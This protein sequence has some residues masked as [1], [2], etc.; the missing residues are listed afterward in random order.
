ML[1]R[2]TL[3]PRTLPLSPVQVAPVH[4]LR[5]DRFIRHAPSQF[6]NGPTIIRQHAARQHGAAATFDFDPHITTQS[7][8]RDDNLTP[9]GD[10]R[11]LSWMR[12]GMTTVTCPGGI[13]A[14]CGRTR[15]VFHIG[16][17]IR[18]S[19]FVT[20]NSPQFDACPDAR[21]PDEPRDFRW[22][23]SEFVRGH[24]FVSHVAG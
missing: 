12:S 1:E 18:S 21:F 6:K 22:S 2:A 4:H 19:A 5:S 17:S 23:P 16:N 10:G 3:A 13:V 9:R 7:R 11:C 20:L 14:L 24:R 8:E 15:L